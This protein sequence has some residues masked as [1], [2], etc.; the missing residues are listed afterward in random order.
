MTVYTA[1]SKEIGWDHRD[2]SIPS[3]GRAE[4]LLNQVR[5]HNRIAFRHVFLCNRFC[6]V[7]TNQEQEDSMKVIFQAFTE[8]R[9]I[10]EAE[11]M[12]S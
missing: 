9:T 10:F 7:P 8:G 11:E 12:E 5:N 4:T 1:M 3:L 2:V 6:P